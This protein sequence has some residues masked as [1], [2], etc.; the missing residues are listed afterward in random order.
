VHKPVRFPIKQK[1]RL[2]GFRKSC[3]L[4]VLKK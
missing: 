1:R 4:R 3:F 2:F